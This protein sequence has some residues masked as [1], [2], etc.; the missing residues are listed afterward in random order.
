[1]AL[2][3][4][5]DTC[6]ILANINP[7][8][9]R[10]DLTARLDPLGGIVCGTDDNPNAGLRVQ[11]AE[12]SLDINASNE[13]YIVDAL[14]ATAQRADED[15]IAIP[16]TGS[17]T[18]DAVEVCSLTVNN[19]TDCDA[20]ILLESRYELFYTIDNTAPAGDGVVMGSYRFRTS[21]ASNSN[22]ESG[23][24]AVHMDISGF[25]DSENHGTNHRRHQYAHTQFRIG[26]GQSQTVEMFA[27]NFVTANFLRI[28]GSF[29]S[30]YLRPMM[31]PFGREVFPGTL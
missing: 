2:P 17:P 18:G 25:V 24:A 14:Y 30:G 29:A 19:P 12:C 10:L 20:V 7:T 27:E 11:T 22:L 4:F 6:S 5:N 28:T 3:C 26:A 31:L 16:T 21:V 8:N 15:R 1:M 9:N 23:S 13:L